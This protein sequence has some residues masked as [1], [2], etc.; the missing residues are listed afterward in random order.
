MNANHVDQRTI[1]EPLARLE[2]ELIAAYLANAGVDYHTLITR[3]DEESRQLLAKAAL[4]ASERLSEI[5][6]RSEYLGE[7]HGKH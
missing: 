2:R 6:A 7:L 5:Q 4:Y 1:E 3:H